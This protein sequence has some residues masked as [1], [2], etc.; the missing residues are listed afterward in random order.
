MSH[1]TPPRLADWILEHVVAREPRAE[2]LVGDVREEFAAGRA[3]TWY[4]KQTVHAVA[5]A[6]AAG[7]RSHALRVARAILVGY[8]VALAYHWAC[9]PVNK[10][11]CRLTYPRDL[12]GGPGPSAGL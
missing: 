6:F 2:S 4:W 12:L 9:D 8:A 3:R 11:L 10:M 1:R 7:V 5:L